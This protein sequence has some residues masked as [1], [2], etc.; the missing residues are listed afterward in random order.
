MLPLA[1]ASPGEAARRGS[2]YD[3]SMLRSPRRPGVPPPPLPPSRSAETN[4]YTTPALVIAATTAAGLA[5]SGCGYERVRLQAAR[6]LA[7]A[8]SQVTTVQDGGGRVV[9]SGCGRQASYFCSIDVRG[10][11]T[12][13]RERPRP[14][15]E[16][17]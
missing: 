4:R 3:A 16:G 9:A 5:L 1:A 10:A 6:D 13:V 11:E 15:S 8:S 2:I 7:C 12:C 17:E 14:P